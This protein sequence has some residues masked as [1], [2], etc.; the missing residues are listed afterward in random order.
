MKADYYHNESQKYG[1]SHTRRDRILSL[2]T[3]DGLRVL[4]VGCASGAFGALVRERGN[5][6]GG[7]EISNLAARE[8]RNRLN[9]VWS[10]DIE[11]IWP[12]E[13]GREDMD[14]VI[15]G[16]VLEHIFDPIAVLKHIRKALKPDGSIII[17]TPNFMTW[18]NRVRFL[19]GKFR[20]QEQGMFDFGHIRWFT[21]RY[22]KEVLREAGFR[23]VVERHIIF[24][25]KLTRVL[26][27]FPSLFAWQFVVRAIR[28][29][30]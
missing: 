29:D 18:T 28:N 14:V 1:M 19:F 6:V 8:A 30:K 7:I 13:L 27:F 17:T 26:K 23:I 21:Y 12:D 25:G 22:L 16:E 20:Y 9:Q 24:P 15:A 4:E 2:L 5:W 11:D 10:F 3:G